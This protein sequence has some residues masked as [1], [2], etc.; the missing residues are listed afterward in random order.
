MENTNERWQLFG[1]THAS[2]PKRT[3]KGQLSDKTLERYWWI[4]D[5]G[6]VKVTTNYNDI[7]KWP[8][9]SLTGGQRTQYLAISNNNLIEKYVHRLVARFFIGLPPETGERMT[10]NH[11]DGNKLNNHYTNLE[12]ITY[13]QNIRHYWDARRANELT[14][15]SEYM[16]MAEEVRQNMPRQERDE[17][18]LRLYRDGISVTSIKERTGYSG[19]I[20][21]KVVKNWRAAN[22]IKTR[23]TKK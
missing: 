10:V 8:K 15:N 3:M 9:L 22:N 5:H 20:V 7:V 16:A 2:N 13:K 14:D 11:I 17:E 6:R 12:W 21:Y 18:I 1:T 19:Y 23:N 4:S